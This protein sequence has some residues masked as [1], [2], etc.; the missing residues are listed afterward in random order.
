MAAL[1]A[2]NAVGSQPVQSGGL[3]L[4]GVADQPYRR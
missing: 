2:C 3:D 1:H 4:T